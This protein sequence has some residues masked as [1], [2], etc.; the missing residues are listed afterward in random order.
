MV[1]AKSTK[2]ITKSIDDREPLPPELEGLSTIELGRRHMKGTG[3]AAH[4]AAAAANQIVSVALDSIAPSPANP[5]KTF[6][7]SFIDELAASIEQHGLK[8]RIALLPAV[9]GRYELL[10]GECRYRAFL[11]LQ[12]KDRE[13][14]STVP[15]VVQPMTAEEA[16]DFRLATFV[17]ADLNPIDQARALRE[18][19][20]AGGITQEQLGALI[21]LTQGAIANKLRLLKAPDALQRLVISGEITEKDLREIIPW[22]DVP[23]LLDL[24]AKRAKGQKNL[25]WLARDCARKISRPM[26][27]D[28]W[29]SDRREFKTTPAIEKELNLRQ[30]RHEKR[31]FNV[32][33]YDRLQKEALSDEAKR[34]DRS[35]K[36]TASKQKQE[37]PAERKAKAKKQQEIF[38][39]RLYRHKLAWLQGRCAER[40]KKLPDA[41][42][43]LVRLLIHFTMSHDHD[44]DDDFQ[45]AIA[46]A[47]GKKRTQGASYYARLDTWKSLA[48]LP[49]SQLWPATREMLGKWISLN[50]EGWRV[51]F[52]PDEIESLASELQVDPRKEWRC[53]KEFLELHNTAQLQALRQEWKLLNLGGP[54][55]SQ[56]IDSL[57]VDNTNNALPCPKELLE[58]KGVKL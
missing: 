36:A 38:N 14:W 11:K 5:R 53:T 18:R 30:V 25:D 40:L 49:A 13:R 52:G 35:E 17:R 10:D 20:D 48:T 6:P 42:P 58:L 57:M 22:S 56:V 26:H 39:K 34:K 23:G 4:R 33:L 2:R 41:E 1:T 28:D 15:A 51:A 54:K 12:K 47:G 3:V 24:V 50:P 29:R 21:G 44:R 55:R 27:T 43:V 46:A 9:D 16:R 32:A 19:L 8:Q 37:T 7:D 45:E 31:A